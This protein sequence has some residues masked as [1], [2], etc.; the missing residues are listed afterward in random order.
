MELE[1]KWRATTALTLGLSGSFT[2]AT[3]NG[4]ISNL[5]AVDGDRVPYFPR[6]ILTVSG[7]YGIPMEQGKIVLSADYTY[8]S[9]AF[10]EFSQLNPLIREIPSSKVLNSSIGYVAKRWSASLYGTNLTGDHLVSGDL[11]NT[12]GAVQPG[13]VQFWGRPL[14]IGIHLHTDF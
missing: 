12:Y 1:S 11:P 3:A 7:D 10:T 9:D 14:T 4:P 5:G 6:T 13:D 8:R 2:D